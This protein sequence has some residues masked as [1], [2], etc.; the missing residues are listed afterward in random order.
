MPQEWVDR[1]TV[2]REDFVFPFPV[3]WGCCAD[4][5]FGG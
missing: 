3:G 2:D 1:F 5:I 4:A